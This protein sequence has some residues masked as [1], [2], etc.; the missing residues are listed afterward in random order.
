[1]SPSD[2]P[3]ADPSQ[4]DPRRGEP[5]KRPTVRSTP[6]PPPPKAKRDP[7]ASFRPERREL[8]RPKK[9]RGG[10]KLKA[11]E[12][13]VLSSWIAQRVNRL[14]ELAA[15]GEVLREGTE[16]A[17]LGQTKRMLTDSGRVRAS[18][19]GRADKAYETVL[20]LRHFT[21]AERDRVI[22][23]MSDQSRHSAQLL[24][25]EMP[26]NIEDLFAPM[27][28]KLFPTSPDDA[29]PRCTCSDWSEAKPWCKHAVCVAALLSERLA[30]APLEVFGLRGLPAEDLVERL[31]ERRVITGQGPGPA[32]VYV[33]HVPGLGERD[34]S[35]L[36][37]SLGTFWSS[38][39]D[40]LITPPMPAAPE[41]S[42]ILLRRLGPSP[43][44]GR[45]PL[46]GLLATCYDVI[47]ERTE[48]LR[49]AA[50]RGEDEAP[51]QGT[52]PSDA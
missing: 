35:A 5:I 52:E 23:A 49:E 17:R 19:Q 29:E 18:V 11:Q 26:T 42:H 24:A 15:E 9:V 43:F 1:M 37:E 6:P 30:E 39:T 14:V 12:G 36:E 25:G 3:N 33:G 28:L 31:R 7:R 2:P 38:P 51:E 4:A 50:E 48:A 27:G 10:V 16:Y 47:R 22:E 41:M 44:E 32:P 8:L 13:E 40:L 21:T 34:S 45:F 46:V 20:E